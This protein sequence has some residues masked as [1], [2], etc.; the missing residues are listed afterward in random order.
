MPCRV[1]YAGRA[2]G[3][4]PRRALFGVQ[5]SR[6]GRVGSI[7]SQGSFGELPKA[8]VEYPVV[9]KRGNRSCDASNHSQQRLC[10]FECR[11]EVEFATRLGRRDGKVGGAADIALD[12]GAH[13]LTSDHV[14]QHQV[15]THRVG[16]R[17][18][19][20]AKP[21]LADLEGAGF[22]TPQPG[23]PA[24][25]VVDAFER[26]PK[27]G[28]RYRKMVSAVRRDEHRESMSRDASVS[29]VNP[30]IVACGSNESVARR[31]SAGIHI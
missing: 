22:K 16:K 2:A 29:P 8:V 12:R 20:R 13:R 26:G 4:S 9:A 21:S 7:G 6:G 31:L 28:R 5:I 24:S 1:C 25:I 10:W 14:G 18:L 3:S 27:L 23:P 11:G 19:H 30:R 15:E 17:R